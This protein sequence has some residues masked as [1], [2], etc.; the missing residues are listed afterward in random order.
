MAGAIVHVPVLLQEVLEHLPVPPDGRVLDLTLGLGGH[1]EAILARCD[2]TVRYLGVDRDPY[3]RDAA[4]ARLGQDA[5]LSILAA[6]YEDVWQDP[7][8]E[9]W[10]HLQAPEGLDVV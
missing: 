10:R 8:F 7:A 2:A 4:R 1:A 9:A 5:R 3:A 6:T